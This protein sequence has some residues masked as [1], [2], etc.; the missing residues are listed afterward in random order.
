MLHASTELCTLLVHLLFLCGR[1]KSEILLSQSIFWSF[2]ILLN[3]VQEIYDNNFTVLSF[4][5]E[6]NSYAFMHLNLLFEPF[7]YLFPL[8]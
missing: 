1:V 6:N 5:H 8:L 3:S 7:L 4:L 2:G